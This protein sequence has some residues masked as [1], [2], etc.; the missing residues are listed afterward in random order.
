MT[1]AT[2]QIINPNIDWNTIIKNILFSGR[3]V[4]NSLVNLML[5]FGVSLTQD[6]ISK[7]GIVVSLVA[8]YIVMEFAQKLKPIVKIL[9]VIVLGW[10]GLGFFVG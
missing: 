3:Y 1:N 5:N 6:Q 10:I 4:S 8:I 7:I 2:S 9:I